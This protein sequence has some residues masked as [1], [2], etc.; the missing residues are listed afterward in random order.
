[1]KSYDKIIITIERLPEGGFMAGEGAMTDTYGT[2]ETRA[3]AL[4]DFIAELKRDYAN[5]MWQYRKAKGFWKRR[6]RAIRRFI[7]EDVPV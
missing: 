7:E 6:L 3:E 5:G 4:N 2:G 1:M